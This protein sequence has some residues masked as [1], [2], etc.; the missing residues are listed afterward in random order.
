VAELLSSAVLVTTREEASFNLARD[1]G[2]SPR[3]LIQYSDEAASLVPR[4]PS[5][6]PTKPFLALTIDEHLAVAKPEVVRAILEEVFTFAETSDLAIVVVP[7]TGD[8]DPT[9]RSHDVA[10]SHAIVTTA[11]ERGLESL[12][13]P[14]GDLRETIWWSAHAK[15]V[16]SS[17][18]HP[19][20]F[21]L[22][23]ATPSLFVAQDEYTAQKGGGALAAAGA[24]KWLW[25]I[26]QP[27]EQFRQ[28]LHEMHAEGKSLQA[29][30]NTSAANARQQRDVL[31][32]QLRAVISNGDLPNEPVLIAGTIVARNYL[33]QARVLAASFHEH[34][35]DSL[36]VTLVIDGRSPEPPLPGCVDLSLDDVMDRASWSQMATMYSVMEF[37]T[38]LKPAFLSELLNRGADH[39]WYLDPDIVVFD[40]LQSVTTA[41]HSAPIALTPHALHPYPRDKAT[42]D[43]AVLKHAGLYNLGFIGVSH[44]A[45]EFLSW[46]QERLHTDATVDLPNALFTDQRWVDFVPTLFPCAIVRDPTLNVAYWN[47]HERP[48]TSVDGVLRVDGRRLGFFHFSGFSPADPEVVSKHS[49]P[50]PRVTF[51]RH[52]ELRAIF[53]DYASAL[54]RNGY[55]R[56]STIAYAL[57]KSNT[58]VVIDRLMKEQYRLQVLEGTSDLPD[59]FDG[60]DDFTDWLDLTLGRNWRRFTADQRE[61]W[62]SRPDLRAAFPDIFG[63]DAAPFLR[64]IASEPSQSSSAQA[65]AKA[66]LNDLEVAPTRLRR[67]G[68]N[69]V[70]YMSAEKGMGE[71]GRRIAEAVKGTGLPT[72]VVRRSSRNTRQAHTAEPTGSE[73]LVYRNSILVVNADQVAAAAR[74]LGLDPQR[75]G[76][77]IGVWFWELEEFPSHLWPGV[78]DYVDEIWAGSE[79]LQKSFSAVAP[80]P[81]ERITLEVPTPRVPAGVE[82]HHVGLDDAFTFLFTFD[83]NSVMA[84]KN[85]HGVID[86]YRAAF[87]EH[88]GTK[89]LIRAINGHRHQ[90]IF[91]AL[92]ARANDRSDI[93]VI[94]QW[95]T[96]P[97]AQAQL[98]L[99]D[100]FV[101]LH[102]SEGFGY[103]IAGAMAA[104]TPTI[105][106]QYSGNLD[107]MTQEN[108]WL[109]PASMMPVGPGALPYAP[110]SL[111]ADPDLS[112]A[113]Q[114]MRELFQNYDEAKRRARL[115][116]QYLQTEHSYDAVVQGIARILSRHAR[117][118]N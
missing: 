75:R 3:R 46:W 81:V 63:R 109:I 61:L 56:H 51:E 42:P 16:V 82:R 19:I 45:K 32:Q 87:S 90:R 116:Q 118:W 17:R 89:L 43:E 36:F 78:F 104:G 29:M 76:R 39:A 9:V 8:L 60:T 27:I 91:D 71:A 58:G 40:H 35:P 83:A 99:A 111:W 14:L 2:V 53:D 103:N 15:S 93:R 12:L 55:D 105:A 4:R 21:A 24:A 66:S 80:V 20:V 50:Q 64:W 1:L 92:V 73:D 112:A 31:T 72:H 117:E 102:R 84:R 100:C 28:L 97:L 30:L 88:A 34:Y 98:A 77:T 25:S 33:A 41:L 95:L 7:H 52:P 48:L 114:A 49:G 47:L 38:A 54:L 108:S 65:A 79:F 85:P 44:G 59:P 110:T 115:G 5:R 96:A 57:D 10:V 37:A 68:W 86:A 70:G 69:V 94:D 13:A 26:T 107:Y 23:A 62:S 67:G 11:L 22:A 106:T 101:S 113:A 18:Y 74:S 6:V